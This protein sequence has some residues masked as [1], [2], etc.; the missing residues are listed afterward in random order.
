V[1]FKAK[2]I[3]RPQPVSQ[4]EQLP[5]ETPEPVAFIEVQGPVANRGVLTPEVLLTLVLDFYGVSDAIFRGRGRHRDTVKARQAFVW[6]ARQHLKHSYP[7]L[8]IIASRPN[9]SS[10]VTQMRRVERRMIEEPDFRDELL[11][12]N[13]WVIANKPGRKPPAPEVT[14]HQPAAPYPIEGD[15]IPLEGGES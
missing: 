1:T 6:L 3:P 9:H 13:A 8:A 14:Q 7:E 5:P 2:P 11:E 10:L 15:P 12:L 4:P